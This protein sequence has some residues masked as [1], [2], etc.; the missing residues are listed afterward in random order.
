MCL[1]IPCLVRLPNLVALHQ[2]FKILGLVHQP[3]KPTKGSSLLYCNSLDHLRIPICVRR[4][5]YV[6]FLAGCSNQPPFRAV[7][8]VL[9]NIITTSCEC[10]DGI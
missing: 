1:S 9:S 10:F 5:R 2:T 8:T 3:H 4:T 6:N 7:L